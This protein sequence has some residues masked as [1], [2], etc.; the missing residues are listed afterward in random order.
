MI[1]EDANIAKSVDLLDNQMR[2]THE[3]AIRRVR[4]D[5]SAPPVPLPTSMRNA[6]GSKSYVIDDNPVPFSSSAFAPVFQTRLKDVAFTGDT[7]SVTLQCTVIGRPTPTVNWYHNESPIVDDGRREWSFD[8]GRAR[9]TIRKPQYSDSGMYTC[10]AE[11]EHGQTIC[12]GRLKMG[13]KSS[14]KF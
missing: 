13:G 1:K 7:E 5:I 11:N 8:N 4:S 3:G 6:D 9:L 10:Q 2:K 12:V 14:N